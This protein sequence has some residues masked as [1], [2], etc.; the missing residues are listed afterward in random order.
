MTGWLLD[1]RLLLELRKSRPDP[2]IKSWSDSQ[3]RE[4]LFVST[5]TIAALR[6]YTE[7]RCDAALQAEVGIWLDQALRPWFAGRILPLTEDIVLE[8]RRILGRNRPAGNKARQPDL[9]LVATRPRTPP[10]HLH[11]QAS[12][13]FGCGRTCLQPLDRMTP[14]L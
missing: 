3:P 14:V 13:L 8:W 12:R 4:S 7:R 2:R 1:R 6:Y 10:Y 5:A 9:L 11:P